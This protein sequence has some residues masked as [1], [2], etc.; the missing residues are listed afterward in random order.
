[1]ILPDPVIL[2]QGFAKV[3]E[4]SEL[5]PFR[6][7]RKWASVAEKGAPYR[8]KAEVVGE[9]APTRDAMG[10]PVWKYESIGAMPQAYWEEMYPIGD[11]LAQEEGRDSVKKRVYISGP[12]TSVGP[13]TWNLPAFDKARDKFKAMGWDV[14]SPADVGR[15]DGIDY[16]TMTVEESDAN[17]RQYAQRDLA[18]VLSCDAIAMLPN[19]ERSDG[20]QAEYYAAKWILLDVYDASTGARLGETHRNDGETILEEASRI[21]S[22]ERRL[23]Y[24]HPSENH[25]CTAAIWS[26]FLT[27]EL[28]RPITITVRHLC[29]MMVAQKMSRDANEQM[30]DNLVDACGYL[31]N[32]EQAEEPRK[33]FWQSVNDGYA[34][35]REEERARSPQTD[36]LLKAIRKENGVPDMESLGD[37]A[38]RK[39][40]EATESI[41]IVRS[42]IFPPQS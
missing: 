25:G 29:W 35:L 32:A 20:A 26:A 15:A 41:R 13:P 11:V 39:T 9:A 2:W 21:T 42:T 8:P 10:Q 4:F 22:N 30:R 28:R 40:R 38:R 6:I 37:L 27:R 19:W 1:M 24:G 3:K 34:A 31:R 5:V 16:T 23:A 33:D 17:R 12:M 14:V 36:S 7:V 18:L